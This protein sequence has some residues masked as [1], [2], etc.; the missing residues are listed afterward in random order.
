MPDLTPEREVASREAIARRPAR[1][2][3]GLKAVGLLGFVCLGLM[4]VLAGIAIAAGASDRDAT[5]WLAVGAV[6]MG[7]L[8]IGLL[9]GSRVLLRR[10]AARDGDRAHQ[11]PI[12]PE[13]TAEEAERYEERFHDFPVEHAGKSERGRDDR[14]EE[15]REE[16]RADNGKA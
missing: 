4:L 6:V 12:Q 5:V 9:I 16:R 1:K 3:R 7:L 10:R 13:T 15:I 11:D 8:A 2:S 14:L